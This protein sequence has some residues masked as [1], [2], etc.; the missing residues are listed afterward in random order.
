MNSTLI[1]SSF[2]STGCESVAAILSI[3]V[4]VYLFMVRPSRN[5]CWAWLWS[6]NCLPLTVCEC[7]RGMG[8]RA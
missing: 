2:A 1:E 8:G 3:G 7:E 5:K 6:T 4:R